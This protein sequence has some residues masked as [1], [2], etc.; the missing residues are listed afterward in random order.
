LGKLFAGL[1]KASSVTLGQSL[2]SRAAAFYKYRVFIRWAWRF[3]VRQA[4]P[5]SELIM[6]ALHPTLDKAGGPW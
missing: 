1:G 2:K 3:L 5:S 6:A 4:P